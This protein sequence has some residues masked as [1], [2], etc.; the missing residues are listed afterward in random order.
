MF[1]AKISG[2]LHI[3]Q[4]KKLVPGGGA[5]INPLRMEDQKYNNLRKDRIVMNEIT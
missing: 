2:F 5:V 4:L 1:S 3:E